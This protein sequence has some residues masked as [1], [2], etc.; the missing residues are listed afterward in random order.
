MEEDE[1]FEFDTIEQELGLPPA[2]A[3]KDETEYDKTPGF[4]DGMNESVK[5]VNEHHFNDR[6]NTQEQLDA[7]LEVEKMAHQFGMEIGWCHEEEEK[8]IEEMT[9]YLDLKDDGEVVS[10]IRINSVG[11][12]EMGRMEGK[13]FIGEPVDTL[14]DFDEVLREK[15]IEEND[16]EDFKMDD[17]PAPAKPTTKPDTDTPPARPSRRPFTP[18]PH[19]RPGEEP[20][21]K[22]SE[23]DYE[24]VV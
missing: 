10:K 11:D 21:P 5:F 13:N 7:Y 20:G 16:M 2:S 9:V 22:A 12:I 8:D 4:G 18:P 14:T 6:M 24:D 19:I 15:Q 3:D 17:S 23:E 1:E